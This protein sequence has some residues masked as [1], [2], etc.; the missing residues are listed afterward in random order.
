MAVPNAAT[1][2]ERWLEQTAYAKPSAGVP[3]HVTV[4]FPFLPARS[5][6]AAV[7]DELKALFAQYEPFAFVLARCLRWPKVLYLEPEPAQPFVELT[8]AVAARYP[9][10]PPYEGAFD[11]IV[12]HLTVAEGADDLLDMAERDVCTHLPIEAHAGEVVLLEEVEPAS[13]RWVV[14][15]RLP[16]AG[17]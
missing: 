10:H 4:L 3:P 16:L 15:A 9:E 11:E 2:V 6:D 14:H 5:L 1:P 8:R 17:A 13:A 12:P 7:M